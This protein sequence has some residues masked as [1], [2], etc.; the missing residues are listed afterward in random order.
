MFST[1][2]N[3]QKQRNTMKI[4]KQII[5]LSVFIFMSKGLLFAQ[6]AGINYQALILNSE[7][8]QI[9]G[10]DVEQ[11]QIALGLEDV[12]FRF[13]I[14]N[15]TLQDLYIEEQSTTTDENGMVSLIVG[16]GTPLFSTFEAIVWNGT[17]KY[18]NI[19]IDIH[20]QNQGYV[21]LDTQ[22]ILY[23]PQSGTGSTIDIINNMTNVPMADNGIGDI[24][25]VLDVDGVGNPSLMVWDGTQWKPAQMDYDPENEFA[26]IVALDDNDRDLQ[27][28]NPVTGEQVWN[29]ACDCIQVYDGTVW[30]DI[31]PLADIIA[32]NGVN[33]DAATTTVKLGGALLEPTKLTTDATNTLSID[34]LQEITSTIDKNVVLIDTSSGVISRTPLSNIFQEEVTLTI[35]AN[36]GQNLFATPLPITTPSKV[37]VYRNGIRI[38]F[39]VFSSTIVELEPTAVCFAGDEIRI[40]QFTN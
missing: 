26:L 24:I 40:V 11:N 22:K 36:D 30:T 7:V 5:T 19:E 17:L 8:I 25:W 35:A 3:K 32:T 12:S 21:F 2:Y 6:S 28:A 27:F 37:N 13:T 14:T 15:E 23:L 31:N 39:I 38:D 29:Q 1:P 9:P 33:I 18:L 10:A 34:G 4:L 20:S 16:S